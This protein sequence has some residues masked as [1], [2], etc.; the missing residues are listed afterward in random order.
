MNRSRL[1][2]L[3][4]SAK[5]DEVSIEI[6]GILYDISEELGHEEEKFDGFCTAYPASL[7]LRPK[8]YE[9]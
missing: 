4:S 9:N 3:L 8:S 1:I 7:V 2:R 5:E 6:E